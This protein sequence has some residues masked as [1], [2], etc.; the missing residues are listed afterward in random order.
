MRENFSG[1]S[2]KQPSG[3]GNKSAGKGRE[4]GISPQRLRGHEGKRGKEDYNWRQD[5]GERLITAKCPVNGE[6]GG[7]QGMSLAQKF[8]ESAAPIGL[9]LLIQ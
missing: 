3:R 8:I 6:R 4:G 7:M 2:R 5:D 9:E 1:A